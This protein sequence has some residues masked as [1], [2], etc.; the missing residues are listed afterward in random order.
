MQIFYKILIIAI[1][2]SYIVWYAIN[3]TNNSYK[4]IT[5]LKVLLII[6]VSLVFIGSFLWGLSY[7]VE[8]Y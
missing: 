7:L 1:V 2:I 5:F 6:F 8:V 3:H 4:P